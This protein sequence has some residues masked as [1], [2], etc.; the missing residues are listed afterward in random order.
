[1]Q[2]RREWMSNAAWPRGQALL[3]QGDWSWFDLAEGEP[4]GVYLCGPAVLGPWLSRTAV[5]RKG[6]VLAQG[7]TLLVPVRLDPEGYSRWF[8]TFVGTLRAEG[9]GN[10]TALVLEG[11][12]V[13]PMGPAGELI[14]RL[15]LHRLAE[16]SLDWLLEQIAEALVIEGRRAR[17]PA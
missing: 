1:M 2:I 5:L 17:V 13:P 14:D 7:G 10:G 12:Y 4:A 16:S 6:Q 15:L 11:D 8:P 9:A 3:A